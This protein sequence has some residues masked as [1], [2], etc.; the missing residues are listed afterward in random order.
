M[1]IIS[2]TE[3]NN[4]HLIVRLHRF[5]FV[6]G[7]CAATGDDPKAVITEPPIAR[8]FRPDNAHGRAFDD[9]YLFYRRLYPA[10]RAAMAD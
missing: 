8:R 7:L 3:D 9:A 5:S 4:T 1:D 6:L 2:F 10:L